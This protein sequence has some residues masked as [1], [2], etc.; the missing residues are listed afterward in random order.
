MVESIL[1]YDLDSL[2]SQGKTNVSRSQ[3]YYVKKDVLLRVMNT[4]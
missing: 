3:L 1:S 2:K 4:I